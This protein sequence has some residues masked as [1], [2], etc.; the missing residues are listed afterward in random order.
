MEP[1]KRVLFVDDEPR[2]LEGLQRLLRPQRQHWEMAFECGG[3]AALDQ[4]HQSEFDVIV[5]DMRMPQLDGADL[6]RYVADHYPQMV[7]IILSG[8]SEMEAVLRVV[9]VAH[10]FLTKPCQPEILKEAIERAGD[11]QNLLGNPTLRGL[12]G[13]LGTLP[14]RPTEYEALLK[15]LDD[16][17][18]SLRH[19]AQI[20]QRDMAMC[21]KCL[22]LANSAFFG[23]SQRVTNIDR[24]VGFLGLRT[25]KSVVLGTSAFAL[26]KLDP[27]LENLC[28][29]DLQAHTLQTAAISA[30]LV[31]D[32]RQ[33]DDAFMAGVL[34]DIGMLVLAARIPVTYLEILDQARQTGRPIFQVERDKLGCSHAE[35]GAYLLGAWG[36]PYPIVEAVARHHSPLVAT[37]RHIDLTGAIHIA[38]ALV[39][40][41]DESRSNPSSEAWLDLAYLDAIGATARLPEW[42]C[43]A[44]ELAQNG[45]IP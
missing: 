12:V 42:R 22:Q 41:M 2:I 11:L 35:I 26:F 23:L 45:R 37:D 8:H 16:P 3:P 32:P 34:H 7:R 9:G 19:V 38:D 39:Q 33:T 1:L 29:N 43:L 14:S 27:R 31:Q 5:T 10:Q 18:V 4:L 13:Q 36:I 24:A 21:A 40:E 17:N 30:R 6:L 15:L 25:L 28:Y 44:A 20:V